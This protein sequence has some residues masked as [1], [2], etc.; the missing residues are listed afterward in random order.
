MPSIAK[1]TILAPLIIVFSALILRI[2]GSSFQSSVTTDIS[3]D[4]QRVTTSVP[5]EALPLPAV[6]QI[7][8]SPITFN[9][10]GPIVCDNSDSDKKIKLYVQ[11]KKIYITLEI[12][13]IRN[14]YLVNGDCGYKW[15]DANKKGIKICNIKQYFALFESISRIPFFSPEM[16]ISFMPQMQSSIEGTVS[17]V[18]V[19]E[20]LKSCEKKEIDPV[21]FEIPLQIQFVEQKLSENSEEVML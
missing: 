5:N 16:L 12:D 14:Y 10:T 6:S 20:I 13:G 4:P 9:L 19:A 21:L 17:Q 18:D 2:S 3:P 1:I 7:K 11:N 15:D 8:S